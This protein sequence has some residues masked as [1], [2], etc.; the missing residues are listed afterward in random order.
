[1][2]PR[3]EWLRGS[4]PVL[5][6][7]AREVLQAY[8]AASRKVIARQQEQR[9]RLRAKQPERDQ[10]PSV[11][12]SADGKVERWC[13][14]HEEPITSKGCTICGWDRVSR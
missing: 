6:L 1:M 14:L 8:L 10:G 4:M 5:R 7:F 9:D 3:A 2:K 11:Y 13:P 12:V